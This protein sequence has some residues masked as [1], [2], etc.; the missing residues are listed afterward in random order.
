[1]ATQTFSL[2]A[3]APRAQPLIPKIEADPRI[4]AF[5]QTTSGKLAMLACVAPL[6]FIRGVRDPV[7]IA[8]LAGILFL[9]RHTWTLMA[10][11]GVYWMPSLM[12]GKFDTNQRITGTALAIAIGALLWIM[13]QRWPNG[14][15]ARNAR[16]SL[17]G[18]FATAL[19]AAVAAPAVSA[20]VLWPLVGALSACLW[21]FSLA[22][23]DRAQARTKWFDPIRDN[24]AMLFSFFLGAMASTTPFFKRPS[25]MRRMEAKDPEER[26][27]VQLKGLKLLAWS[28][29]AS[30]VWAILDT[31]STAVGIPKLTDAIA[32]STAHHAPAWYLC[33]A[34][35]IEGFL[36]T[37]LRTAVWGNTSWWPAPA[38][39]GSG[40]CAIHIA[41]WNRG[42]VVDFWNRFYYYFKE[43]VADFFFYPVYM[44]CFKKLST[45][46]CPV[47][48]VGGRRPGCAA[49]SFC[50]RY[51]C[52]A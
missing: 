5:A 36:D 34:S 6:F 7:F 15:V 8:I 28:V 12:H 13:I 19:V 29:L 10:I 51:R 9:P 43:L 41:H 37:V 48:Y 26:A 31:A 42:T 2:P 14:W 35:L 52:G 45:R 20:S 39:P 18:V 25:A 24:A 46:A 21:I 27:I 17:L 40:C 50:A 22:L 11:G 23:T 49:V 4:V 33:W 47:R 3:P 30:L 44:R 1:M 38:W 16:L 32:A